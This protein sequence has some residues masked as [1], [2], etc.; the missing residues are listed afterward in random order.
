ML[1]YIPDMCDHS[2][3]VSF[4]LN[5]FIQHDTLQNHHVLANFMTS[6]NNNL[7]IWAKTKRL[8]VNLWFSQILFPKIAFLG[9]CL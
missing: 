2:V 8:C 4:P 7:E 9:H 1:L 3:S 6:S 5:N